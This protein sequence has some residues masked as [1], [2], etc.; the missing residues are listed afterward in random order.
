MQWH[1]YLAIGLFAAAAVVI[2]VR[3]YRTFFQPAK[4]GCASGCGTCSSKQNEPKPGS[5][6]S[7]GPPPAKP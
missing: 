3:A 5:L 6:L 4:S 7:I 1:D 2:A